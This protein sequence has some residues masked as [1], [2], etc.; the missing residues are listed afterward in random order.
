MSEE[1]RTL[2]ALRRAG[3]LDAIA[4][5]WTSAARRTRLDFDPDTGHDQVWLGLTAHKLF[6][7]RM[8]RVFHCGKYSVEPDG[9][10]VGLDVLG[11]GLQS[12][13]L[14][15]MPS[16]RPG[17]V[18]REDLSNSPGWRHRD[19]HWLIS[20]FDFG[21]LGR[22]SWP[23]KTRTKQRAASQFAADDAEALFPLSTLGLTREMADR[24][25][26]MV[27]HAVNSDAT[28]TEAHLGRPRFNE[29]GGA[30]WIWVRRL[31]H[32]PWEGAGSRI[33]PFET[34]PIHSPD[35]PT[36]PDAPVR[37]RSTRLSGT[38]E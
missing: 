36:A 34:D 20:S 9:Q 5:A 27:A 13:E 25:V 19:W 31:D 22:I 21:N 10:A 8:D 16:I 4:W 33:R 30:P 17:A 23:S 29:D 7:D 24:G 26:L 3:V 11:A 37:L 38:G 1:D 2:S 15:A 14:A 18:V 32:A 12:G 35:G 28:E 6:R